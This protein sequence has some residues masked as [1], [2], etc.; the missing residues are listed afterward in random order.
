MRLINGSP[1]ICYEDGNSLRDYVSVKDVANANVLCLEDS[2]TNGE[3]YNV[4]G[5]SGISVF[6]FAQKITKKINPTIKP[7]ISQEYRFGDTRHTISSWQKIGK[8]GWYPK[9]NIDSI[10]N[11]YV[12]WVTLQPEVKDLYTASQK[13]MRD[14]NVLRS[15]ST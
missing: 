5:L 7:I 12:E 2:R 13:H 4:G 3:S 11:E 10:I 14:M 15:V 6:D 8:L 1:P 9:E